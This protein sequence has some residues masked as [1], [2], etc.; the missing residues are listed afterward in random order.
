MN[1]SR[2]G[3]VLGLAMWTGLLFAA[4]PPGYGEGRAS[5]NG[6]GRF[7]LGREI[8]PVMG[9][10]GADW[11]E[12]PEREREERTSEMIRLLDLKAG[13]VVADIGSGTGYITRQLARAVGPEGKVHAV[14][15]QPEMLELMQ[16]RLRREGIDNVVSTL[17]TI[18]D[19]KLPESSLDLVVMVDVY[20]EFSHPFEMLGSI[21]RALK[22]GGRVVFVEFKGENPWVPILPLHKMTEAQVKKEAAVHPDLEWVT[23]HRKL[24]WQHVVVFKRKR[25]PTI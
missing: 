7:Y 8:A 15:I 18:A 21:A 10:Q 20:H 12:R 4:E 17:G 6:T 2:A 11:L 19:P 25:V 9:H 23:T 14:E 5:E 1:V 3:A 16:M 24:P 13:E 22:P